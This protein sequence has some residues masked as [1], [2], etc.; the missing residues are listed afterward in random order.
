MLLET[1][2]QKTLSL[3]FVDTDVGDAQIVGDLLRQANYQKFIILENFH[4]LKPE[5]QREIAYD[6]KTFHEL[7]IR[8]VILGVWRES[9]RLFIDNPDLQE[10]VAEIPVEP[11][12][13]GDFNS[14]IEAGAKE[15]NIDIPIAARNEFKKNSYGN[16]GLLQE[17]LHTYCYLNGITE[18]VAASRILDDRNSLESPKRLPRRPVNDLAGFSAFWRKFLLTAERRDAKVARSH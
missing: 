4:Y 11:W 7:T 5:V 17:F 16:V 14:V 18:T 15:L 8:F 9:N 13:D 12:S 2:R 3:E 10:R 6:L 1:S